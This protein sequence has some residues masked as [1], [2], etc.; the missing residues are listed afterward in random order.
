MR[1]IKFRKIDKCIYNIIQMYVQTCT[2]INKYKIYKNRFKVRAT[3]HVITK[4]IL[5]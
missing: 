5:N 4:K 2:C 3:V 1:W